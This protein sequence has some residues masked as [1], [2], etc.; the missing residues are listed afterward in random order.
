MSHTA[1]RLPAA[2]PTRDSNDASAGPSVRPFGRRD[3]SDATT[4]PGL[5]A[6]AGAGTGTGAPTATDSW[7]LLE[8]YHRGRDRA[9]RDA[10]VERYL[11]LAR[12]LA[13][14]Y[15]TDTERDDL[16]QVAAIGLIKALDRFDPSRGIAFSSFAVPT[17]LGELK[18]H[19]RD[20][21]WS[22][23]VPR[24]LQ[25]LAAQVAGAV[26]KLSA[27]L[28]RTPTTAEIADHC[29]VS[30]EQVLEARATVTAHRAISLDLP[31]GDDDDEPRRQLVAHEDGGYENVERAADLDR[32][33]SQLSEREEMV[34]RLRFQEDLL[35]R[36]I[37]ERVGISQMQVSRLIAQ[38][39]R[40]LQQQ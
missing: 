19:F 10:L 9:D 3:V 30:G 12:H 18:R 16:E 22:V 35:Q 26:E 28:G 38:A 32:L 40:T 2:R 37:A 11:P 25:E 8:R 23:R 5:E 20:L 7:P 29:G 34:L 4:R 13:R 17:I 33:L 14:R 24:S 1:N 15:G 27:D 39:I 6:A 21:G 31:A 36:E